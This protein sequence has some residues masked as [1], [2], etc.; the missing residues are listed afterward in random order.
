MGVRL[1]TYAVDIPRLDEFLDS[2]LAELLCRYLHDGNDPDESLTIID[3]ES[4]SKFF[5]SPQ[6]NIS[7]IISADSSQ[8]YSLFTEQQLHCIPFLQYSARDQISHGHIHELKWLLQA[9]SNCK[10]ISFIH[11]L[12]DGHRRWWIGSVLQAANALLAPDD[13]DKLLQLFRRLLRGY[14]CGYN[15]PD[16]DIGYTTDGFPCMPQD[17][18]SLLFGRWSQNDTFV[19]GSLFTQTLASSP[20][21]SLPPDQIGIA[22]DSADC[23]Q[24]VYNILT[25]FLET[26][27]LNFSECNV[28]SFIG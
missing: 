22:P 16:G 24:W 17:D 18:P 8:E 2:T 25:S 19:A 20:T 13:Y 5:V 28:V 7:G 1:H 26:E 10:G 12:L 9:F 4:R 27:D 14:N 3:S 11:L 23:H 21:F 6:R 15:I